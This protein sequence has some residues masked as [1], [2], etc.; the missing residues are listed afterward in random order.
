[1]KVLDELKSFGVFEELDAKIDYYLRARTARELFDKV[2]ERL[3]RVGS[4]KE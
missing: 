1:M 4:I 2:L 3:E